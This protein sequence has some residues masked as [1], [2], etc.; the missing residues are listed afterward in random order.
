MNDTTRTDIVD[1]L[2]LVT[3]TPAEAEGIDIATTVDRDR[4]AAYVAEFLPKVKTVTDLLG[5][6]V[7]AA[8]EQIVTNARKAGVERPNVNAVFGAVIAHVLE[9]WRDNDPE[10]WNR[11]LVENDIQ[12]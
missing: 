5:M 12:A 7:C 11:Y 3:L 8:V 9:G 10:K 6:I 2:E 1:M 4:V